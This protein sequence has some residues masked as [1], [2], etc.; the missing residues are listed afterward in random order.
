MQLNKEIRSDN[1]FVSFHKFIEE[2]KNGIDVNKNSDNLYNKFSTY[3]NSSND[4]RNFK[5]LSSRGTTVAYAGL[6]WNW[7]AGMFITVFAWYLISI[8]AVRAY[9]QEDGRV[10]VMSVKN[11]TLVV[12]CDP[13]VD[14]SMLRS[15][16][17]MIISEIQGSSKI[18][19]L[20]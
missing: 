13:N 9:S 16:M 12:F 14:I 4:F 17:N 11:F 20:V 1:N 2:S 18:Q 3:F 15:K 10:M 5:D 8:I 6:A 7:I 19:E